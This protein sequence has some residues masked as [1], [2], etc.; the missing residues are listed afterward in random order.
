VKRLKFA[1][2]P[3]SPEEWRNESV[4]F[5]K[6]EFDLKYA[7]DTG[8]AIAKF[9]EGLKAGKILGVKCNRCERI[10]VPPRMFCEKCFR[11]VDEWVT[12]RDT[13]TV[14]TFSVSY[15]NND[16]SRREKPLVVAV[17]EIHGASPGMGIL[18]VLGEV[19]PSRVRVG[20]QVKAVWKPENERVGAITDIA[21]FKPIEVM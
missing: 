20:M 11:K 18:H 3:I 4:F 19:E 5:K 21:Y 7:W 12:L 10:L 13:G 9:L 14:N 2:T 15:V 6:E 8:Y 17:I 1:G 16:A